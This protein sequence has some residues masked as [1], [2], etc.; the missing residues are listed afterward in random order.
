MY[1]RFAEWLD[2][3]LDT[4]FP[5]EIVAFC[6]NLYEEENNVKLNNLYFMSFDA[7]KLEEYFEKGQV[8]KLYLNFSD[9]W[10]KKKHVK[11]RLTYKDFLE[12]YKNILKQNGII[13]FKTDNRL[14]FEFSL[15]SLNNYGMILSNISLD[16]HNSDF[17][18]NIMTEYEEKFSKF[19][20]IYRLEARFK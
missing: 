13:E 10:P 3:C 1:E 2:V 8:E 7:I 14:L 6:F 11:R 15:E 19:G 5:E 16:L 9:P 18:N 17:P 4:E 20:P 12:K